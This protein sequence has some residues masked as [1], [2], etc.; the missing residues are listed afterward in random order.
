MSDALR[1]RPPERTLRWVTDSIGAGSRI[2]ATVGVLK[3]PNF[4]VNYGTGKDVSDESIMDAREPL[5]I[6]WANDSFLELKVWR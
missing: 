5:S 3:Q 6:R 4:Q 1:R 2:V